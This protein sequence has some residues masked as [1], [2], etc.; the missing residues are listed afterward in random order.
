M[1]QLLYKIRNTLLSQSA[2]LRLNQT[3]RSLYKHKYLFSKT[4]PNVVFHS[5]M[6]YNL[7]TLW[8]KQL[9]E[10]ATFLLNQFNTPSSLLFQ[11]LLIR[12]FSL[13][14]QELA[15]TSPLICWTLIYT[16]HH[17]RYNHIAAQLFLL[18]QS[19]TWLSF[20]CNNLLANNIIGGSKALKDMLPQIFLRTYCPIMVKYNLIYQEQ[21]TSANGSSLCTWSQFSKRLFAH[22]RS[23]QRAPKFYKALQAI[24]LH[25]HDISSITLPE[26]DQDTGLL[27]SHI[28]EDLFQRTVTTVRRSHPHDPISLTLKPF[29]RLATN[30]YYFPS[31]SSTHSSLIPNKGY[32]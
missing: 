17:Y 3:I 31:L 2:C 19:D 4:A 28:S 22:H 11:V 9:A 30:P 24:F 27:L 32:F 23:T 8:I 5:K 20:R 18:L 7:S 21:I 12:L 29:Y 13:Q 6:F 26:I 14:K 1:P 10:Q 16:F 15:P 25:D